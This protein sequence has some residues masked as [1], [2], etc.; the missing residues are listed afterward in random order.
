MLRRSLPAGFIVPAQPIEPRAP[1]G[2]ADWIHEIK[3]D[4]YRLIVRKHGP[5]VRLFTRKGYDWSGRYP[6]ITAAALRL[7]AARTWWQT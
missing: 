7:K 3:H 1:P 5:T 4:G 2:G 6:G